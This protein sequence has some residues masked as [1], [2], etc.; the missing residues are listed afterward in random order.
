MLYSEAIDEGNIV[1]QVRCLNDYFLESSVKLIDQYYL[2]VSERARQLGQQT[3]EV[4]DGRVATADTMVR[5]GARQ[6]VDDRNTGH[7]RYT[8]DGGGS[9]SASANAKLDAMWYPSRG[10][11]VRDDIA[12]DRDCDSPAANYC[13][14]ARSYAN[15]ATGSGFYFDGQGTIG[16][17]STKSVESFGCRT[18]E[19]TDNHLTMFYSDPKIQ[20]LN[21]YSKGPDGKNR[22]DDRSYVG[23]PDLSATDYNPQYNVKLWADDR[24]FVDESD[25]AAMKRYMTRRTFQNWSTNNCDEPDTAAAQIPF[26]I[27][28]VHHRH[29]DRVNNN[30]LDGNVERGCIDRR[31]DMSSVRCRVE[32]NAKHYR[33][34]KDQGIERPDSAR[35][36]NS[37]RPKCVDRGQPALCAPKTKFCSGPRT[38]EWYK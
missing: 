38:G 4:N 15:V 8:L 34:V 7:N 17:A 5:K 25:P 11:E 29:V 1:S 19:N 14:D 16:D 12:A 20:M 31:F 22:F 30:S 36:W 32:A 26:W 10:R 2:G 6:S 23:G 33:E 35:V 24:G 9:P 37:S 3:Y 28:N 27:R 21:A 13:T 18:E